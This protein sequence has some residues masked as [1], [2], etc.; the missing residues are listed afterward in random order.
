MSQKNKRFIYGVK[1]AFLLTMLL[2]IFTACGESS[3]NTTIR[4]SLLPDTTKE[5]I[6]K[7]YKPLLDYVSKNTGIK[8]KLILTDSYQSLYDKFVNKE[9]DFAL[10]GG[11]TYVKAHLSADAE[12][13]IFR[14]VD[15]RFH[16]VVLV[17][18]NNL[19]R[20][21]NDLKNSS[22]SF[23]SKLSTSGHL[24][25]RYFFSKLGIKPELFFKNIKYSGSHAKTA[26]MVMSG[27][28]HA[29]VANSEI[30]NRMFNDGRLNKNSIKILWTSPPFP[31]YVWAIQ[32]DVSPAIKNNIREAFL[33]LDIDNKEHA[34][35][36]NFIGAKYYLPATNQNFAILEDIV[37]KSRL[38]N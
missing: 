6:I 38:N 10:F 3:L 18:K 13:L 26:Q 4:V 23:G 36:L 29:G 27:Q 1:R 21:L 7:R 5:Q 15:E 9:I 16:S 25:P 35:I 31:D 12:P 32:P 19:A 11:Y 17:R 24:M 22:F 14:D 28:V 37:L 2:S 20:T 34:K 33:N 30:I 8:F